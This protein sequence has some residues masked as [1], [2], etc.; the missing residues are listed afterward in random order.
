MLAD[1]QHPTDVGYHGYVGVIGTPLPLAY[2]RFGDIQHL[3][4]LLLR[5]A[6]FH[7]LFSDVVSESF[8]FLHFNL[9][10]PSDSIKELSIFFLPAIWI[11]TD[12][13]RN[14]NGAERKQGV[15]GG[16][17]WLNAG[18]MMIFREISVYYALKSGAA[19]VVHVSRLRYLC[20]CLYTNFP[21]KNVRPCMVVEPPQNPSLYK[22]K[23]QS[24]PKL[25][26]V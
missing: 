20:L 2:R 19:D 3:R 1:V 25:F 14:F 9:P 5:V 22:L 17:A 23:I 21:L 4:K 8:T 11:I 16:G 7:P 6:L 26:K 10:Y 12:E 15:F 13:S 24:P 18:K